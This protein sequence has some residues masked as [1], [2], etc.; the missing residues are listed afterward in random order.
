MNLEYDNHN[1]KID[2]VRVYGLEETAVAAGLPK[3]EEYSKDKFESS[4]M[5][6]PLPDSAHMK[7][8]YRLGHRAPGTSHDCAL[9]GIVVQ[10]NI[11]TPLYWWPEFQRYHFADIIS[12][13]STMHKLMAVLEHAEDWYDLKSRFVSDMPP[14]TLAV[15]FAQA[16]SVLEEEDSKEGPTKTEKLKAM[17]PSG[18]LQTARVTTNYR[19]LK[20]MWTQRK[21]HPLLVWRG[22]CQWI[23]QLPLSD[24]I[25]KKENSEE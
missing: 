18:W 17:L 16:K 3:M 20:T 7:R 14:E 15:F 22:F 23:D 12:S 2:N 11:T 8:I 21:D 5:E 6:A 10:M 4:V 13:T 19:Q 9:C 1:L 24:L 25:T